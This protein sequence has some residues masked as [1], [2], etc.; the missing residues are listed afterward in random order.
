MIS[1]NGNLK[2]RDKMMGCIHR[3]DHFPSHIRNGLS[4]SPGSNID[5]RHTYVLV[6]FQACSVSLHKILFFLD[7]ELIKITF[8]L[9][10]S[11]S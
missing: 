1:W 11:V 3:R 7:A 9:Q 6:Y 4:L 2:G 5:I 10:I 8:L